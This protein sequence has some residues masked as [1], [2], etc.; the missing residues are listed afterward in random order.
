MNCAVS[1]SVDLSL[2]PSGEQKPNRY[3]MNAIKV[4]TGIKCTSD[5]LPSGCDENG[6]FWVTLGIYRIDQYEAEYKSSSYDERNIQIKAYDDIYLLGDSKITGTYSTAQQIKDLFP[7]LSFAN[8]NQSPATDTIAVEQI[9]KLKK[10]TKR[11][12]LGFIAGLYGKFARTNSEGLVIFSEPIEDSTWYNHSGVP[13]YK[14]QF[15]Q[16][17]QRTIDRVYVGTKNRNSYSGSYYP[18]YFDN[19]IYDQ[20]DTAATIRNKIRNVLPGLSNT[21]VY[22]GDYDVGELITSGNILWSIGEVLTFD[23]A[24][25]ITHRVWICKNEINLTGGL[26]MTITSAAPP[27]EFT[28][29]ETEEPATQ[30]DVADAVTTANGYTDTQVDSA[31][32]EA[33][34]G[35]NQGIDIACD[36]TDEKIAEIGGDRPYNTNIAARSEYVS[37]GKYLISVNLSSASY[38]DFNEGVICLG[39]CLNNDI[40][41]DSDDR[42]HIELRAGYL[43]S[44]TIIVPSSGSFNFGKDGFYFLIPSGYIGFMNGPLVYIYSDKHGGDTGTADDLNISVKQVLIFKSGNAA[45]EIGFHYVDETGT[46]TVSSSSCSVTG[47]GWD[48]YSA[49]PGD[50]YSVYRGGAVPTEPKSMMFEET[51]DNTSL[52]VRDITLFEKKGLIEATLTATMLSQIAEILK[53]Q[54]KVID[55]P[56]YNK[57]NGLLVGGTLNSTYADSNGIKQIDQMSYSNAACI[58]GL[59]LMGVKQLRI[60]YRRDDSGGSGLNADNSAFGEFTIPLEYPMTMHNGS[61]ALGEWYATGAQTNS[62]RNDNRSI[63]V[64]ASVWYPTGGDLSNCNFTF[65]RSWSLYGTGVTSVSNCYIVSIYACY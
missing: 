32:D 51:L 27:E 15:K 42:L 7:E 13:E 5:P 49:H 39:V 54:R 64:M 40:E 19:P 34:D 37:G 24:Y 18:V 11:E 25:G 53:Y 43:T 35:I 33:F 56:V 3:T 55:I 17:E 16:L 41:L 46:F 60:I 59:N 36:Y 30:Q 9:N 26:S 10:Y 47:T 8:P 31:L 4:E 48:K 63:N 61:T 62:H 65:N 21:D 38:R 45:N 6:I 57:T 50:P 52:F 22:N 29:D 28:I 44:E 14:I 12:A 2:F 23:D 1:S 58:S 20:Y